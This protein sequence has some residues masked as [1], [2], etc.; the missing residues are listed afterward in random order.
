MNKTGRPLSP[1]LTIYRWP[2]TMTLSILHRMTG[3]ALSIG[4]IALVVWL[5]SIAFGVDAYATVVG[6]MN[7]II[8]KLILLG[9]SFAFFFHLSNGIRHLFWDVGMGFEPRQA[10]ASAWFVVIASVLLT[11]VYWFTV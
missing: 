2:I 5:E 1:H 6:L 8:G 10:N 4:L 9:L 7:T 11:A 3:V